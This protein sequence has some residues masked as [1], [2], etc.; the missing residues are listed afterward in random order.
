[1]LNVLAH[2]STQ[3]D[4]GEKRVFF[5]DEIDAKWM[6]E[7]ATTDLPRNWRSALNVGPCPRRVGSRAF[8]GVEGPERSGG[9]RIQLHPEPGASAPPK[10]SARV[11]GKAAANGLTSASE[12]RESRVTLGGSLGSRA[13]VLLPKAQRRDFPAARPRVQMRSMAGFAGSEPIPA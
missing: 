11:R 5:T 10:G 1:M 12:P 4:A 3:E 2:L 9:R 7:I 8:V 13:G 6:E